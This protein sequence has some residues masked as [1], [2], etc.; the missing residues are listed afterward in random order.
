MGKKE[1]KNLDGYCPW[2]VILPGNPNLT[3]KGI[4]L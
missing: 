3:L 1:K 2:T 4:L